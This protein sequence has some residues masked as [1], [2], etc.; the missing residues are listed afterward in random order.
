MA[1][2]TTVE[3]QVIDV[4]HHTRAYDFE[5]ITR[6]C[7]NLAGNHVVLAVDCVTRTGAARPSNDGIG[8]GR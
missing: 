4:L 3:D 5:A 7:T 1:Q 8:L 2:H 6:H